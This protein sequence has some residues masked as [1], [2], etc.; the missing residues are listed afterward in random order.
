MEIYTTL[1]HI[2]LPRRPF[3]LRSHDIYT[4]VVVSTTARMTRHNPFRGCSHTWEPQASSD[5]MPPSYREVSSSRIAVIRV[6]F[7]TTRPARAII[8][9]HIVGNDDIKVG[10]YP[11]GG[12]IRLDH[13]PLLSARKGV[14]A[15]EAMR[16]ASVMVPGRGEAADTDVGMHPNWHMSRKSPYSLAPSLAEHFPN[17]LAAT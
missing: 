17:R 4:F 7:C 1:H 5:A 6:L 16:D 3:L 2:N 10:I 9:I 12:D 11:V 14:I 8:A 15:R 13:F